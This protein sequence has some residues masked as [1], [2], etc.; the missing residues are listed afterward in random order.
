MYTL[1]VKLSCCNI[2][3]LIK[4]FF[5]LKPFLNKILDCSD[6]DIYLIFLPKIELASLA[7]IILYLMT[8][9]MIDP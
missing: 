8:S 9:I 1:P 2:L 4:S 7:D 6:S 5:D 3:T